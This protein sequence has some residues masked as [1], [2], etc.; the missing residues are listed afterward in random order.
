MST[1][2]SEENIIA[3]IEHKRGELTKAQE[4]LADYV[5]ENIDEIGFQTYS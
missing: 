1:T 4:L 2:K 3:L 5:L